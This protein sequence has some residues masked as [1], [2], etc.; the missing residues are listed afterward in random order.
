MTLY[1]GFRYLLSLNE[2]LLRHF[3]LILIIKEGDSMHKI[4]NSR[5]FNLIFGLSKGVPWPAGFILNTSLLGLSSLY[6][7]L[8]PKSKTSV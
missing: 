3:L 2:V 8:K 7:S 1:A 6:L 4:I 5:I